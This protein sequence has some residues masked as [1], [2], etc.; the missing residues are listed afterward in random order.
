MRSKCIDVWNWR[1]EKSVIGEEGSGAR[2][3]PSSSTD[4]CGCC[5]ACAAEFPSAAVP[6]ICS[7]ETICRISELVCNV[8]ERRRR[9]MGGGAASSALDG[10]E[11]GCG[12]VGESGGWSEL[13]WQK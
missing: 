9:W 1:N 5:E 8:G 11:A 13:R 6:P 12:E 3:F 7:V 4:G 10:S 2:G